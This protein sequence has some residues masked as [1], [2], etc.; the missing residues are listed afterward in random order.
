MKVLDGVDLVDLLQPIKVCARLS[1]PL[2]TS[3]RGRA[4]W[5]E[6]GP[7]RVVSRIALRVRTVIAFP[8]GQIRFSQ[9]ACP[10]QTGKSERL[11]IAAVSTN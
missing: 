5:L 4:A 2:P 9:W 8:N 6:V 7:M 11:T 1:A 3:G 10:R